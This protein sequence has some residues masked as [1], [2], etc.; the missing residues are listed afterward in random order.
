LGGQANS[1]GGEERA[2]KI[3]PGLAGDVAM[4]AMPLDA[5]AFLKVSTELFK[6]LGQIADGRSANAAAPRIT[7]LAAEMKAH[8]PGFKRFMAIASD[9]QLELIF[10]QQAADQEAE[11]GS[12]RS[13][14]VA[15][16]K[17]PGNEAFRTAYV[18]YLHVLRDDGTI[19]TRR[20]AER[21]LAQL[22]Q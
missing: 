10:Q 11:F 16:A 15:L 4:A 8:F 17:E 20:Q 2:Q 19:G 22:Q 7:E 21:E 18:A 5:K 12:N 3:D 6:T 13:D 14:L 9:K 1:A